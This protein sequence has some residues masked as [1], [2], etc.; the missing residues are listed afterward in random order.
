MLLPRLSVRLRGGIPLGSWRRLFLPAFHC[1]CKI[2]T[3]AGLRRIHLHF[4]PL[5]RD[6]PAHTSAYHSALL[7]HG[8]ECPC[9]SA[10]RLICS[11]YNADWKLDNHRT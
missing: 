4:S 6:V 2:V 8:E 1:D 5:K 3:A 9:T 10:S 11:I 7:P